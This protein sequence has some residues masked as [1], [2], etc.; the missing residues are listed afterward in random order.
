MLFAILKQHKLGKYLR[1]YSKQ[2]SFLNDLKVK[3]ENH[4]FDIDFIDNE[5]LSPLHY[6]C[7]FNHVECTEMLLL[8]NGASID[9][10]GESG[11]RPRDMLQNE[12]IKRTF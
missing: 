12:G 8:E 10:S 6:S 3:S 2:R 5:G 11:F 1:Q 4:S 9:L 7:Q